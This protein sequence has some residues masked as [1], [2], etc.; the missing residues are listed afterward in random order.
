M[1]I[2]NYTALLSSLDFVY[3]SFADRMFYIT[4]YYI[5]GIFLIVVC[6]Q[7]FKELKYT[8]SVHSGIYASTSF[9]YVRLFLNFAAYCTY[10]LPRWI[11]ILNWIIN[12]LIPWCS[13]PHLSER[14]IAWN[15]TI[16]TKLAAC[17]IIKATYNYASGFWSRRGRFRTFNSCELYL[18][19]LCR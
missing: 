9:Y 10:L 15:C 12:S 7:G 2:V 17:N 16:F 1:H 11:Y 19:W 13:R 8:Y 6:K 18:K 3:Y 5:M 4:P 14:I